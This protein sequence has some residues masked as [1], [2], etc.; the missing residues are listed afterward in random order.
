MSAL[1]RDLYA[2][3]HTIQ[4][5]DDRRGEDKRVSDCFGMERA[6]MK[7]QTLRRMTPALTSGPIILETTRPYRGVH[8]WP[9]IQSIFSRSNWA[10]ECGQ[11]H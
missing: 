6:G 5:N 7:S 2:L 4:R 3:A 1:L 10:Q 9:S 11:R 8:L